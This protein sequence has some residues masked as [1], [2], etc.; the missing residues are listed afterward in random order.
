M[1]TNLNTNIGFK[2]TQATFKD[3]QKP[4]SQ[5][6]QAPAQPQQ[7]PVAAG[8]LDVLVHGVAGF[9]KAKAGFEEYGYGLISG[10]T[11]GLIAGGAILSFDW[12]LG[13]AKNK[14]EGQGWIKTPFKTVKGIVK[15]LATKT[16]DLI[17]ALGDRLVYP[18]F[19]GPQELYNYI[20][21]TNTSST[22]KFIAPAVGLSVLAYSLIK[23]ELK[24]NS[25]SAEIEHQYLTGHR[26]D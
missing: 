1:I 11:N 26:K 13:M 20:K 3:F 15:A 17:V 9:H 8:P 7:K 24:Y 22:S 14:P 16:G 2:A 18:F 25:K 12:A 5:S 19:K 21:S 4:V 10:I 23:S 6:F